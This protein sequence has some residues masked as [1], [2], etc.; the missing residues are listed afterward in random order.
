MYLHSEQRVSS[1]RGH[2][3]IKSMRAAA[4]ETTPRDAHPTKKNLPGNREIPPAS[5]CHWRVCGETVKHGTQ[6]ARTSQNKGLENDMSAQWSLRK[7]VQVP[8]KGRGRA[9]S[10]NGDLKK[11]T[12][13]RYEGSG[14]AR[15]HPAPG[16]SSPRRWDPRSQ[17]RKSMMCAIH[18]TTRKDGD[19]GAR[20]RA[21]AT[22]NPHA[23]MKKKSQV[24][25]GTQRG[26]RRTENVASHAPWGWR[27]RLTGSN[28]RKWKMKIIARNRS[29]QSG[30]GGTTPDGQT[31]ANELR[32]RCPPP[33]RTFG[34]RAGT[35]RAG[36]RC[37]AC[38]RPERAHKGF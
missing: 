34:A 14:V 18:G 8:R 15:A 10:N 36:M 22:C 29:M 16:M 1:S 2:A 28:A 7:H 27:P 4:R 20:S 32:T 26:G 38:T 6:P 23:S 13:T 11:K 35:A 17:H 12:A 21:W 37:S 5:H 9:G 19:M 24:Q 25:G 33:T 30:K 3:A 31:H